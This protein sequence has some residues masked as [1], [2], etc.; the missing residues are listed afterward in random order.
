MFILI[1]ML[2]TAMVPT[3]HYDCVS[4]PRKSDYAICYFSKA[5]P[6]NSTA[7]L[8]MISLVLLISLGF[9]IRVVKLHK[10]SSV[11]LVGRSRRSMSNAMRKFLW[12]LYNWREAPTLPQRLAGSTLY[13]PAL[14]LFLA[15]RVLLDHWS[16][17]FFEA[18]KMQ[19]HQLLRLTGILTMFRCSGFYSASFSAH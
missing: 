6:I 4:G 1:V 14:A 13:F 15:L 19:L 9:A 3:G 12:K 7:C 17:M 16:S 11:S 5:P 10:W 18:C 2:I 8:S